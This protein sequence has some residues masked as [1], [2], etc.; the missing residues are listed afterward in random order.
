MTHQEALNLKSFK[1]YCT[2]GGIGAGVFNNRNP[3]Q[4]HMA[5][6]PQLDE[7]I[8]W[9]EALKRGDRLSATTDNKV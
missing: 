4:P 3:E 7:W 5:W 6:C 8:E 9:K 1:E 2:C